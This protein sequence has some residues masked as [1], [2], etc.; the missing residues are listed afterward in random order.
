MLGKISYSLMIIGIAGI[1]LSITL[2]S[3]Y[4]ETIILVVM[5]F[6][7]VMLSIGAFMKSFI[8]QTRK[9]NEKKDS[10]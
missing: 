2:I 7:I 4:S 10:Q 6:G 5:I 9:I 1:L 8:N 3:D